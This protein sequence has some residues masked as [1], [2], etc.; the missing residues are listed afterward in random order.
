MITRTADPARTHAVLVGVEKYDAGAAW[1]RLS[2]LRDV[3]E[4]HHWLRSR[5]VPGE[6]IVTLF[7]PRDENVAALE[8]SKVDAMQA[9]SENVRKAFDALQGKSGDLLFVYWGGHGAL[10]VEEKQRRLFLADATQNNKRNIN[11]DALRESLA[12][13]YFKGFAR[14]ILIVDA[15]ATFVEKKPFSFPSEPIPCGAP[16]P[17]EQF[18]FFAARPGQA[19][20]D[21]GEEERGLLSRELLKQIHNLDDPSWPPDMLTLARRVQEEFVALRQSGN[22]RDLAQTP[23]FQLSLDWDGS[24]I[25]MRGRKQPP[26]G[27]PPSES[28]KLTPKQL[29]PLTDALIKVSRMQT[30]AGRDLLLAQMRSEISAAVPRGGDAASDVMNVLRTAASYPGGLEEFL[31]FIYQFEG[32]SM[33]WETVA[34]V[35][36]ER[37]PNLRLPSTESSELVVDGGTGKLD[38]VAALEECPTLAEK[39]GR[40]LCVA[41]LDDPIPSKIARQGDR[42]A[43]LLSIVSTCL[44]YEGG[45]DS[46]VT[47]VEAREKNS[48]HMPRVHER[49]R[50]LLKTV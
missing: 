17:R 18:I 36:A 4:F 13:T 3:L 25:E 32:Q 49:A 41:L 31:W 48:V 39:T 45:I 22:L 30:S 15:C 23:V 7:S 14:Q 34:K 24:V 20:K 28:G 46:L 37:F 26:G 21:L 33:A 8:Q 43:D 2:I 38:L 29:I 1:N 42:R 16:L 40:D 27:L 35:V 5:G 19:A 12:S 10:D 6:Q 50:A 47:A 9:T 44:D 11:F